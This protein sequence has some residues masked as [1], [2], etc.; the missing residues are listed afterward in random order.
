MWTA[1]IVNKS[2]R[3]DGVHIAVEFTNRDLTIT[4]DY[5]VQEAQ[6]DVWLEDQIV[7][8]VDVLT[9]LEYFKDSVSI[10]SVDVVARKQAQEAKRAEQAEQRVEE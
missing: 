8:K 2:M 10:G 7:R 9:A 5:K 6:S 3:S 1:K 4:Q